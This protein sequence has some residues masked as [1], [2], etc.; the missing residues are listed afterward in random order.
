MASEAITSAKFSISAQPGGAGISYRTVSKSQL[1]GLW[2][3]SIPVIPLPGH[4]GHSRE[5]SV[6]PLCWAAPAIFLSCASKIP[7]KLC[8]HNLN[9]P[10]EPSP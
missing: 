4:P 10:A 8:S 5:W 9:P 3:F 2:A 6:G 1:S 7:N